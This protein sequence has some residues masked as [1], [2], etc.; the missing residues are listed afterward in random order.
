MKKIGKLAGVSASVLIVVLVTLAVLARVLITPE[1][2]KHAI[3]PLAS[4]A[5][6]REVQIGEAEF[7]LLSGIT[8]KNLLVKDQKSD[9][10]FITADQVVLRYQLLPLLSMQVII[11]EVRL[12]NPKIRLARLA[13]GHW[14]FADLLGDANSAPDINGDN[15]PDR[16]ERK[17]P[18]NLL[19]SDVSITGGQALVLD[20][21]LGTRTPR[22]YLFSDLTV[23]ARD[24]SPGTTIPFQIKARH[25]GAA[26][27]GD[28]E[29]NMQ[30]RQGN[31]HVKASKLDLAPFTA[32]LTQ[33]LP[34]RLSS[35]KGDLDLH[36]EI[37]GPAL[38]AKGAAKFT[39][40]NLRLKTAGNKPLQSTA[41]SLKY[42]IAADLTSSAIDIRSAE[43][44]LEKIPFTLSG[45]IT[46]IARQPAV[47]LSLFLSRQDIRPLLTKLP[48]HLPFFSPRMDPEGVFQARLHFTGPVH[49]AGNLL[50]DGEIRLDDITVTMG[51]LR[52]VASGLVLIKGDTVESEKLKLQIG[53]NQAWLD[54]KADN[55]FD[56]T[57]VITSRITTK[58]LDLDA[59]LQ[60]AVSRAKPGEKET[61]PGPFNLPIKAEGKISAG[62]A[63]YKGLEIEDFDLNYHLANNILSI[64]Q[65][66]GKVA[67]G[68]FNQR[69]TVDLRK[70]GVAWSSTLQLQKVEAAP[71]VAAFAPRAA[72]ILYGPVDLNLE[73]RGRGTLPRSVRKTA[74][75][76]G[77]LQVAKGKLT[78]AGM[79]Q[80][81]ASYLDLDD[82]QVMRV[83]D[84][85]GEFTFRDGRFRLHSSFGGRE[86]Q[87]AASGT[88]GYDG[89]LDLTLST[90]L[91]PSLSQKL[92]RSGTLSG[93]LTDAE[94]WANLPLKAKG[95]HFA[96]QFALE[97][98]AVRDMN[99]DIAREKRLEDFREKV[100]GLDDDK[101]EQ[102]RASSYHQGVPEEEEPKRRLFEGS[103]KGLLY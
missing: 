75:G 9:Q 85:E 79:V 78:G 35:L 90:R 51:G 49:R 57:R 18:F 21:G 7:D 27:A 76:K 103:L 69:A 22:R 28:G 8:L 73:I 82:L 81:L 63:L 36:A 40:I 66:K 102:V 77:T 32:Y 33:K 74:S 60:S 56:K 42:D 13:N 80:E 97:T 101:L 11:D 59:L 3:T 96:P 95:T 71:I 14:D 37:K 39:E 44:H 41:L 2:V 19:V 17:S 16:A 45:R 100:F 72:G 1:R 50:H 54:I 30:T 86:V 24:I 48:G 52:P 94:G 34:G 91:S 93:Y 61:E 15:L 23:A 67:D 46:D 53:E 47:D 20:Y 58:H 89:A 87:M 70:K 65:M 4:E 29:F 10:A 26:L 64:K 43:G 38:V 12:E 68:L 25:K 55:L 83:Q 92:S 62:K 5:L 6:H 84:A 88:I 31:L 98:T 99:K